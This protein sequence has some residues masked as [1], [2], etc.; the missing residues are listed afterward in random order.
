[1]T[2]LYFFLAIL[3]IK[4]VLNLSRFIQCKCYLSKY[5]NYIKDPKW[6][7]IELSHQVVTLFKN[8]GVEDTTVPNVQFIGFGNFQASN[9]SVFSN[10]S[11]IRKDIVSYVIGMFHQ[12]I[13][14]YR[15]RVLETFNPLYWIESI[16]FLPKQ[17]L[18]YMGVSSES[19]MIKVAQ[20]IYWILV[21][22]AGLLYG[23]FEVDI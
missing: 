22:I 14:I 20:I 18:N 11:V 8:A 10:I 12:A 15:T 3:I 7:F 19:I 17:I 2:I 13:G 4:F 16:I 5:N 1:M 6:G 9:P 21:A 23:I